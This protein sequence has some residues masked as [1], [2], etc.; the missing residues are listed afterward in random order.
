MQRLDMTEERY[1][2]TNTNNFTLFSPIITHTDVTRA[3]AGFFRATCSERGHA[4][5]REDSFAHQSNWTTASDGLIDKLMRHRRLK[6][7]YPRTPGPSPQSID[8]H[9]SHP[10]SVCVAKIIQEC[11]STISFSDTANMLTYSRRMG[12]EGKP[13]ASFFP[14]MSS[15]ENPPFWNRCRRITGL[16]TE[17]VDQE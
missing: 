14:C 17:T 9:V 11:T 5:A 3:S 6:K 15:N 16:T 4:L 8:F 1:E 10:R 2:V 7:T 13:S 12:H